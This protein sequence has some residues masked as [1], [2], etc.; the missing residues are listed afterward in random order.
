LLLVLVSAAIIV[1]KLSRLDLPRLESPGAVA[2]GQRPAQ[3]APAAWPLQASFEFRLKGGSETHGLMFPHYPGVQLSENYEYALHFTARRT[4]WLLLFSLD[5]DRRLALMVPGGGPSSQIP[6][7][8]AGQTTR[9]PHAPAWEPVA[10]HS[11]RR[12]FYAVYLD[13]VAAA[14]DLVAK[15]RLPDAS[16]PTEGAL[17]GKLDEMVVAGGCSSAGRPCVLTLEYEVF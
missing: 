3:P 1:P 2:I 14:D 4:G 13:S 8:E 9:F 6:R 12:K 16:G 11:G 5:Q 15:S 10:A 7:L 17:A